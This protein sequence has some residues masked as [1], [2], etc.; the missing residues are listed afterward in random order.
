MTFAVGMSRQP[1]EQSRVPRNVAAVGVS[2]IEPAFRVSPPSRTRTG[3][4][5]HQGGVSCVCQDIRR[6]SETGTPQ[7]IR[8]ADTMLRMPRH[9][10][11]SKYRGIPPFLCALH[12]VAHAQTYANQQMPKDS[13]IPPTPSTRSRMPAHTSLDGT[14]PAIPL[15]RKCPTNRQTI[16]PKTALPYAA[17]TIRG[18]PEYRNRP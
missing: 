1:F 11:T 8:A 14:F 9:T 18:G 10:Q 6:A 3:P 17:Y 4:S 12:Q 7:T 15:A 13:A 5:W 16:A 2:G